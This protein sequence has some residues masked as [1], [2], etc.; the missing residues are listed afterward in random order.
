MDFGAG[1]HAA[2]GFVQDEDAGVGKD[3][4]GDGEQLALAFAEVVALFRDPGEIAL[5]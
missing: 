3:G 1:V 2:G 4:A 5:R